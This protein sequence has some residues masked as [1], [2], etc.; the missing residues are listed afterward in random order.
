[1]LMKQMLKTHRSMAVA[2]VLTLT[3]NT[4]QAAD[5]AAWDKSL[6]IGRAHV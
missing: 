4:V 3:A 1:M 5:A 6:K 2:F